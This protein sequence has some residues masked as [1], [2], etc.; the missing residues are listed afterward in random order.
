MA[1]PSFGI[2]ET[3]VGKGLETG[4]SALNGLAKSDRV[5]T[6]DS[7]VSVYFRTL[8]SERMPSSIRVC[9]SR[10]S[11]S[12]RSAVYCESARLCTISRPM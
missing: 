5:L 4:T 10:T 8:C 11:Y 9:L 2:D 1:A 3:F 7:R 12:L 6:A